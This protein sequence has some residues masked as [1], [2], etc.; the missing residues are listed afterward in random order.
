MKLVMIAVDDHE[1]NILEYLM[2]IYNVSAD[3]LFFGALYG[4]YEDDILELERKEE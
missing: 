4:F 1:A 3:A 2:D